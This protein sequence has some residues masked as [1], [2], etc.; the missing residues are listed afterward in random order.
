MISHKTKQKK[1]RQSLVGLK[2]WIL[3][4]CSKS[5]NQIWWVT[6]RRVYHLTELGKSI[7]SCQIMLHVTKRLLNF[8]ALLYKFREENYFHWSFG[9]IHWLCLLFLRLLS[10]KYICLFL[11][12]KYSKF[13]FL[14]CDMNGMFSSQ[15]NRKKSLVYLII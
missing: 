10:L 15:D 14:S 8:D 13:M 2:P 4:P 3:K 11:Q 9:W 1:I 12:R 6:L 7:Q 5:L